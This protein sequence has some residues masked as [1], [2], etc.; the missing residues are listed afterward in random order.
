[1]VAE[2]TYFLASLSFYWLDALPVAQLPVSE[3]WRNNFSRLTAVCK[4]AI[5]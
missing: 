1:M 2:M 4:H 5:Q 3:H